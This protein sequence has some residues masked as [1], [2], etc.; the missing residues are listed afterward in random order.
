MRLDWKGAHFSACL[1]SHLLFVD[2]R[3]SSGVFL[4][5]TNNKGSECK[6]GKQNAS[7]NMAHFAYLSIQSKYDLGR[8][9]LLPNFAVVWGKDMF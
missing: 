9:M 8:D 1:N 7:T 4:Q 6:S 2:L 3:N 5:A